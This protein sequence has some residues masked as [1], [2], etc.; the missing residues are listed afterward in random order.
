VCVVLY[1]TVLELVSM[2][3]SRFSACAP[4]PKKEQRKKNVRNI[5]KKV[6]TASW[7]A[8]CPVQ[9]GLGRDK[10]SVTLKHMVSWANKTTA[11]GFLTFGRLGTLF[12]GCEI[13]KRGVVLAAHLGNLVGC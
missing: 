8:V 13:K 10:N 3:D 9:P 7:R 2:K 11:I 12:G 4:V 5:L 6:K 1:S